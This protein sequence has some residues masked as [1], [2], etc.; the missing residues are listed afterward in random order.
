MIKR[1]Y[2]KATRVVLEKDVLNSAYALK[3]APR[4]VTLVDFAD[5]D[6]EVLT[7]K[8]GGYIVLD[9][10]RELQGG[11]VLSIQGV[12]LGDGGDFKSNSVRL[13]FGE[14]VMEALST[15]GYK[16]ACND[17]AMR[18]FVAQTAPLST[19][20]YGN[21]GFRFVRIEAL[22]TD[23]NFSCIQAF[24]EMEDLPYIG[25]FECDDERL[26]EIWRVGAYTMNLNMQEYIWDGIKRD[27]LV[28]AGDMNPE[29]H[30]I[31]AVFGD[32]DIVGRSLDLLRD[33][34]PSHKWMNT[35]VSYT[36]W[37]I[38]THRDWY[39]YTG[40]LEYLSGQKDYLFEVAENIMKLLDENNE[41][42]P[43]IN[44]YIDWSAKDK[45][46][47][48]AGLRA[49]TVM[50]LE[51]AADIAKVLGENQLAEKYI[52]R[53]KQIADYDI[54]GYEEIKQITAISSLAGLVDLNH[55]AD[56]I[57]KDGCRG[58]ATF[59]GYYA[60][61][62]LAKTGR[63]DKA[64]DIIRQYWGGMLDMGATSFWEDFDIEWIK[65]AAP[66]TDVVP[67][68]KKDIH[69]DF[70]KYCYTQFRHS[71]CHGWASGP[72]AFMSQYVLGIF[73]VEAGF[74]KVKIQPSLGNLKWA[75]GK[76]PTPY[77]VICVEHKVVD[78]RVVTTLDAPKEIEIVES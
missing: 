11:I 46:Q 57:E 19:Q 65:N 42:D 76:F 67:E 53:K 51:A 61:Q 31:A 68:G 45:P 35:I 18:D 10:G 28:W 60:I 37:W 47:E 38:I 5:G 40:N 52:E 21:T 66:V 15:V 70:G 14:S 16:N 3:D 58:F 44:S 12:T 64:L 73:P 27:R 54:K 9:F 41:Y 49:V 50:S 7:V 48:W 39:M 56:I 30:T 1:E 20:H 63:M 36:M 29:I 22:T 75:R 34:T 33:L 2:I 6:I 71:L 43:S 17:H 59:M 26:N 32:V 24:C 23:I 8:K 62:V 4:Q 25:E 78:G 74:K 77:G 69:G 13:S 55:G 72:T